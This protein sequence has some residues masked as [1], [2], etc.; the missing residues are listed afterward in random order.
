L[1]NGISKAYRDIGLH[2]GQFTTAVRY[3]LY[4]YCETA[5]KFFEILYHY[6][7]MYYDKLLSV[8][9]SYRPILTDT[10]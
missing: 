2:G 4:D 6:N 8:C 10:L 9:Y 3:L 7:S 5:V 1:Y